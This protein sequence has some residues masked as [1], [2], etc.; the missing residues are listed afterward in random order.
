MFLPKEA[1]WLPTLE[2]ELYGFPETT[3]DDQVDSVSQFLNWQRD[4]TV[5]YTRIY[6]AGGEN[7]PPRR[8]FGLSGEIS[9][10]GSLDHYLRTGRL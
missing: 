1:P 9:S 10:S 8:P 2:R 7:D 3:H 6:M 4:R 5:N